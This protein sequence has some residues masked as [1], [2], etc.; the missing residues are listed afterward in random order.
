[1]KEEMKNTESATSRQPLLTAEEWGWCCF[2]LGIAL[3]SLSRDR[4]QSSPGAI[5]V[6]TGIAE[7]IYKQKD[8]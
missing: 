2:A 6:L 7:K 8:L 4:D 3:G 1:M 5:K